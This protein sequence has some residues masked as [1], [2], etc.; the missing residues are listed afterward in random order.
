MGYKVFISHSTRD[1]GIVYQLKELLE[2]YGIEAYVA[3]LYP[4]PGQRLSDKISHAIEGSDCVLALLSKDGIRSEWVHHEIGY[5][6]GKGKFI[7][8]LVEEGVEVKGFPQDL[9]YILF[10]REDPLPALNKVADYL[11]RKKAEKER[12]DLILIGAGLLL[13]LGLLASKK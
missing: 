2:L 10:N 12:G 6:K 1:I 9:E 13:L 7:L 4:E 3:E 8:P 11:K 5:A